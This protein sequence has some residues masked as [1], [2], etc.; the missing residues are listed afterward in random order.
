MS[1]PIMDPRIAPSFPAAALPI[2]LNTQLRKNVA[3]A[4][5]VIQS[6]RNHLVAEKKDWQDLRTAAAAIRAHTLANLGTYLEQF[7]SRCTAAGGA[8]HW[9][10]DAAEARAIIIGILREENATEVIKIKTMTSAEIQLNPALKRPAS[11]QLKPTWL[12]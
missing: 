1:A 11:M 7:E 6:K 9:A 8:V 10:G 3:H 12:S 5:D 4:T 2:L